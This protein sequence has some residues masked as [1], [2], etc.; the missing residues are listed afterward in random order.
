[1]IRT[2][3]TRVALIVVVG[4]ATGILTQIGQG[5]LPGD[6][7]QLANAITPWLLV[8]FLLGPSCPTR[9]GRPPPVSRRCCSP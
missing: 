6:W 9:A 2:P 7:S 5:A 3:A 8:A 1:M 4:L